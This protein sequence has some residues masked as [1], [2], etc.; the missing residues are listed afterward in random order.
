MVDQVVIFSRA[1]SLRAVPSVTREVSRVL[2]R[3]VLRRRLL[4]FAPVRSRVEVFLTRDGRR[5][6]LTL[7]RDRDD[8][9]CGG[10]SSRGGRRRVVGL[11]VTVCRDGSFPSMARRGVRDA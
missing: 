11:C 2:P 4:Q 3:D 10:V 5:H 6:V 7:Y 9:A 8:G 1:F